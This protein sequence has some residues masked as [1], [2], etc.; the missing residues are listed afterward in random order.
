[1]IHYRL[2]VY[3]GECGPVEPTA[4]NQKNSNFIHRISPSYTVYINGVYMSILRAL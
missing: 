2:E 3:V 1:M 4:S